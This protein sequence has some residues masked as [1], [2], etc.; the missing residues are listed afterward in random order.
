M[1]RKACRLLLAGVL[2][3]PAFPALAD[4]GL[5]PLDLKAT[6]HVD[7][8]LVLGP[9]PGT[10][11]AFSTESL[12]MLAES[13]EAVPR[14]G[15]PAPT[16][17]LGRPFLWFPARASDD[18]RLSIPAIFG[19]G[20]RGEVVCLYRQIQ[21]AASLRI[22][23]VVG[24][25]GPLEGW[26]N[27]ARFAGA[28]WAPPG[29]D[30]LVQIL[31]LRAG[32]NH[33]LLRSDKPVAG[34]P[35]FIRARLLDAEAFRQ[36]DAAYP[37]WQFSTPPPYRPGVPPRW[38][39]W[40]DPA[41][42]E[43]IGLGSLPCEAQVTCNGSDAPA[44]K[45]GTAIGQPLNLGPLAGDAPV[46]LVFQAAILPPAQ[47]TPDGA[48]GSLLAAAAQRSCTLV[49]GPPKG[50]PLDGS[51][52]KSSLSGKRTRDLARDL[53][54]AFAALDHPVL[55]RNDPSGE[56]LGIVRG[57]LGCLL[58]GETVP[59]TGPWPSRWLLLSAP[60]MDED[61]GSVPYLLR[62]PASATTTETL[63][64]A[65][66]LGPSEADEYY[67]PL[68]ERALGE[69]ADRC[70]WALAAPRL[71]DPWGGL[72]RWRNALEA[73]RRDVAA[74]VAVDPSRN[75]LIAFADA[76]P[77]ALIEALARP[78]GY[79]ALAAIDGQ[80]DGPCAERLRSALEELTP[81]PLFIAA[82]AGSP[83]DPLVGREEEGGEPLCARVNIEASR[84]ADVL[85]S[86][87]RFLDRHPL[88]PIPRRVVAAGEPSGA[89][90]NAWLRLR[91]SAQRERPAHLTAEVVSTNT[92]AIVP[93][94]VAGFDLLLRDAPG[95]TGASAVVLR[96]EAQDASPAQERRVIGERPPEAVS[97]RLVDRGA[98]RYWMVAGADRE[99]FERPEKGVLLANAAADIPAWPDGD[100]GGVA[101]LLAC[102][103]LEA[104][105]AQI[106]VVP[107]RGVEKRQT[108]GAIYLRDVQSWAPIAELT[109][110]TVPL[111]TLLEALER[112]YCGP[113]LLVTAGIRAVVGQPEPDFPADSPDPTLEAVAPK[114]KGETSAPAPLTLEGAT[115]P[116]VFPAPPPASEAPLA[117]PTKIAG[118]ADREGGADRRLHGRL[119]YS[120]SLDKMGEEVVVAAWRSLF[121]RSDEWLGINAS[122]ATRSDASPGP[123][124]IEL[125]HTGITQREAVIHLLEA[126]PMIQPPQADIRPLPRK[127]AVPMK[128]RK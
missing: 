26:L 120:G 32:V 18:G 54:A 34:N 39:R 118:V 65:V 45:V 5:L 38:A 123:A 2:L 111:A 110:A 19:P 59:R 64:L 93:R 114:D 72:D 113:G 82:Q 122:Q 51:F 74:R 91:R 96:I 107:A 73:V 12:A 66:L 85:D 71:P 97:V 43:F 127:Q 22:A 78:R 3:L 79:A 92:V 10:E 80:W 128:E 30:C 20:R 103:A 76:A 29:E 108:Q 50:L 44:L 81:P 21:A 101:T 35:W 46:V 24:S 117:L 67:A 1:I 119:F 84:R 57:T 61:G 17:G 58:R 62:R 104:T 42:Q 125:H 112:D 36:G 49:V 77:G 13:L 60:P 95:I 37:R 98:G 124:C 47:A 41:V 100:A 56:R 25:H 109:T 15:S 53:K 126:E 6:A 87:F 9:F 16:R 94:N 52:A 105:R 83:P 69:V 102:A 33:L 4:V 70:G 99:A 8:W 55:L 27:G 106:A 115:T 90:R 63:A 86:L 28:A 121:E 31:T 7:A 11:D 75:C 89:E 116:S 48:Q 68:H 40:G 14:G 88:P 23:L